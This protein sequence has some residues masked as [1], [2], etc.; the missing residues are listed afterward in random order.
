MM[1]RSRFSR[2]SHR[3]VF[4]RIDHAA[5]RARARQV[6]SQRR[7]AKSNALLQAFTIL[8]AILIVLAVGVLA[9]ASS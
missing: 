3:A 2:G 9:F 1:P 5:K 6:A 4:N 8:I 7:S